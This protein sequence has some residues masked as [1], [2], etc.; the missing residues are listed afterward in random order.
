MKKPFLPTLSLALSVSMSFSTHA[1]TAKSKAG[2][3]TVDTDVAAASAL[4][5]RVLPGACGNFEFRKEK[6]DRS[7]NDCFTLWSENGKIV[8]SGNSANAMAMGLNHYLRKYC[9]TT[10]SWYAGTPVALPASLPAIDCKEHVVARTG[11][12][13]FL[14]YCTYGYTM[15]FWKWADWERFIDWM[16]LNGVNMPLAITGQEAVWYNVWRSLGMT[17]EQVRSYFTG[18]AYLPW[19]RMANIDRWNGPLPKSWL[20]G[21]V[22]LQKLILKRERE[23]LS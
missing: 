17:D 4:A 18:P 16:A 5:A 3:A 20:D 13:F 11:I 2:I 10:V 22:E 12:R 6:K 23:L 19:H 8:V 21:Q 15:P 14:N 7:G 1:S 9:L